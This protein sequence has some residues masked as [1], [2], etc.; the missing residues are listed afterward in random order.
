MAD[1]KITAMHKAFGKN[2]GRVCGDCCHLLC[3]QERS[4]RRHYKCTVYGKS[5]SAATDWAKSWTA[6]GMHGQS[7]A[8]GQVALLEQLKHEKR[9]NNAPVEG[10]VSMF[11]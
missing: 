3:R 10:Q 5:H 4:G 2:M 1:R 8:R 11:E 7:V 6:C 9:P